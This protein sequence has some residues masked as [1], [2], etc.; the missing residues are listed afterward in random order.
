[1]HSSAL[2]SLLV[3]VF[4]G[5][6]LSGGAARAQNSD[7]PVAPA[8]PSVEAGKP[9]KGGPRPIRKDRVF[10]KDLEGLWIT[11]DYVDALRATRMPLAAARKAKPLV[12]HIRK[13]GKKYTLLRTDF[14]RAILLDVVEVEPGAKPGEFRIVA[15]PDASGPVNSAD[16]TYLPARGKAGETRFTVLDF[17]DPGFSKKKFRSFARIEEG[18]GH[19]VNGIAIAGAY[20][21]EKGRPYTFTADGQATMPDGTFAYEL[22]LAPVAGPCE[23]IESVAETEAAP[24]KRFGFE[25]KG[26]RLHLF[27]VT[28]DAKTGLRCAKDAFAVLVPAA[29]ERT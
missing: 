29:G 1:M 4:A 27:E 13:D 6:A 3:S 16:V 22:A 24:R 26:G 5:L 12:V 10:V 21:D 23:L 17:A 14:G 19:L 9:P 2:S 15:A 28:G 20:A 25:W 7:A 11:R 8:A 18:L